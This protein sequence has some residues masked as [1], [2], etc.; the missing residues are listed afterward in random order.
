[1][2]KYTQLQ[3]ATSPNLQNVYFSDSLLR[4]S[5]IHK[6]LSRETAGKYWNHSLN[7][8]SRR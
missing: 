2:L 1:M 4:Q 3:Y 6:Y 5:R 8:V 7:A